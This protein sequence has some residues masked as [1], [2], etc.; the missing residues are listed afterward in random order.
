MKVTLHVW[1]PCCISNQ[2][3][4]PKNVN[5]RG[6]NRGRMMAGQSNQGKIIC[7]S[8]CVDSSSGVFCAYV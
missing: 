3:T 8:S 1:E 5:S 4:E 7:S 2:L 6:A